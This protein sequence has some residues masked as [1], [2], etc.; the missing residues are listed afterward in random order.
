MI[1]LQVGQDSAVSIV[2]RYGLDGPGVESR[3]VRDYPHP[4]RLAL[5]PTYP[6]IEWLPG[7]SWGV[8]QPGRGI[9]HPP[10][11]SAKVKE[12]VG[13]YLYSTSDGL[14]QGE[15]YLLPYYVFRPI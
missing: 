10:P 11:Y 9:D 8:K 6:P 4:S 5:G 13:L 7:L 2:T 14:L 15:L 1:C 3:W 12:R